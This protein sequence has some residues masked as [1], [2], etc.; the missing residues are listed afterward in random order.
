VSHYLYIKCDCGARL[1]DQI[2]KKF[3]LRF[4]KDELGLRKLLGIGDLPIPTGPWDSHPPMNAST[5]TAWHDE[6]MTMLRASEPELPVL[7]RMWLR[8][9]T[10]GARSTSAP[11]HWEERSFVAHAND[12]PAIT[13]DEHDRKEMVKSFAKMGPF[14]LRHIPRLELF[15]PREWIM[16][17]DGTGSM[18]PALFDYLFAGTGIELESA[19][20]LTYYARDF[21]EL[22]KTSDHA[23]GCLRPLKMYF[24]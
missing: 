5:F 18:S 4:L 19:P 9:P 12:D 11:F 10:G 7:H 22:Q 20:L 16:H 1:A 15:A 21:R 8:S 2:S 14:G 17:S 6:A 24:V 23:R 3:E 13:V